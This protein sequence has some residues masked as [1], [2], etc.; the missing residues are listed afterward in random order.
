MSGKSERFSYLVIF[1]VGGMFGLQG[2]FVKEMSAA[3]SVPSWT[4]TVRMTVAFLVMLLVVVLME[5]PKALK[6]SRKTLISCVVFGIVCQ[7]MNNACYA[8]SITYGGMAVAASLLYVG[9]VISMVCAVVLFKEKMTGPKVAALLMNVIGCI[10]AVTGGNF[11]ELNLDIRGVLFGLG[12]G[13]CFGLLPIVGKFASASDEDSP[14]AVTMY[15]F[16]FASLALIVSLR[17]WNNLENPFAPRIIIQ[18]C[19][20]AVV[21]TVITYILYFNAIK[22]ITEASKIPIIQSNEVVVSVVIGLL[23]YR[24]PVNAATLIGF[25]LVFAS[26]V[27]MNIKSKAQAEA[28]EK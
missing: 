4:V 20:L 21:C 10:L 28:T 2:I 14:L 13:V 9:P 8:A 15:S 12:S 16:L 23:L 22:N 25:L 26:I 5:G 3:G 7:A 24:E 19:L 17:A 27:L 18:G 11:T 1:I 6:V